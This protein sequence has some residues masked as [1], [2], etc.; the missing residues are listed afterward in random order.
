MGRA[1]EGKVIVLTRGDLPAAAGTSGK[2]EASQGS[3]GRCG[4]DAALNREKSAEVIVPVI[5]LGKTKRQSVH[6]SRDGGKL[7]VESRIPT[8]G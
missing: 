1:Y 3:F 2:T 7:C 8:W 6:L 5:V 4:G